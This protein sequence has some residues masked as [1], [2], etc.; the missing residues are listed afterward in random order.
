LTAV[1]TDVRVWVAPLAAGK[2]PRWLDPAWVELAPATSGAAGPHDIAAG[3][4]GRRFGPFRWQGA[5]AGTHYAILAAATTFA[6][7]SNLDPAAGL[8][9][10]TS[11]CDVGELVA[12]D[13]N[14][15]MRIVT[16]VP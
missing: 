15:G 3:S 7:E 9:C 1:A 13:N 2:V 5:A 4:S 8:P 12:F 6:D 16:A 11:S 10:A 14:L